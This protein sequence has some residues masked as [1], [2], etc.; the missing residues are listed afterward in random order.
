[1][2][3]IFARAC[4][5]WLAFLQREVTWFSKERSESKIKFS[6]K[7]FFIKCDQTRWS[8]R[9][10]SNLLKISLMEDFTFCT[11]T[12]NPIMH[13]VEQW[14]PTCE[15]AILYI[16]ECYL[17]FKTFISLWVVSFII[18]YLV[19]FLCLHKKLQNFPKQK[20]RLN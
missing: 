1:M 15:V 6:I 9:V 12:V 11:G 19:I 3:D 13:N 20:R 8:Q 7:D 2:C 5:F 18:S 14:P 10:W 4:N 17:E 16:G